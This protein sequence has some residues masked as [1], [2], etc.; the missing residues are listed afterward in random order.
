MNKGKYYLVL[1]FVCIIWG[2]TPACGRILALKVSPVMLTGLRFLCMSA[3]LFAFLIVIGKKSELLPSRHDFA[4]MALMGL[5]GVFL[6]NSLLMTGVKYTTA[7]NTALIESIG[8]TVTCVLAYFV[9]GERLSFKGWCGI[10]LSCV[11]A[12]SIISNGSLDILLNL[13][14]NKG[15]LIVVISESMWSC[16]TVAGWFLSKKASVAAATAWSSLTGAIMCLGL[17]ICEKEWINA[18]LDSYDIAAFVY[19]VLCS[20]VI[21]FLGWNWAA[22][23]VGVSKAGTFV[24]IVPFAGAVTGFL[25]LHEE[26][27]IS[28]FIGGAVV[29]LGMV[30]TTRSKLVGTTTDAGKIIADEKKTALK[31]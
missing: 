17:G 12:L 22:V 25:L 28:Q 15:D 29:V 30:I 21:A 13:S 6:H 27:F 14:F 3:V 7:S 20:G 8:P 16:Y 5:F 10:A 19:L 18:T 2:A 9:V 11:G 26:L 24:Y 23:R 1:A 4:V 31:K